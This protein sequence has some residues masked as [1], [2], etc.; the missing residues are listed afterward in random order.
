MTTLADNEVR[1]YEA[2]GVDS[3]G[4]Q[5]AVAADIVYEGA[6]VGDNGSGY[7]RPLVA[8]DPFLGFATRKCDNSDGAAGDLYIRV[9]ERGYAVLAVTGVTGPG[10]V[11]D[12]VYATDDNTFT[13]TSSGASAIGTIERHISGTTCVVYFESVTVRSI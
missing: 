13:K 3:Y 2:S 12:D 4:D 6:A 10:D 9:M 5:P 1:K 8:A 7:G 11:G